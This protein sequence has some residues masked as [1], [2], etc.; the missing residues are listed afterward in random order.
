M[1]NY[2]KCWKE[3]KELI[4]YR[5]GD[6]LS[7]SGEEAKTRWAEDWEILDMIDYLENNN[8]D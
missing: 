7:L 5:K 6:L 8:N 4:K 1:I 2:E 3:L